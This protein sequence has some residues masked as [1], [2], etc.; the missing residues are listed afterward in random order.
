MG[1]SVPG[2]PL[3]G[4]RSVSPAGDLSDHGAGDGGRCPIPRSGPGYRSIN[5]LPGPFQPFEVLIDRQCFHPQLLEHP[6]LHPLA[7][8]VVHRAGRTKS[9]PRDSLPVNSGAQHIENAFSNAFQVYAAGPAHMTLPP[10]NH[11]F[12][13]LP[14]CVGQFPGSVA[15]LMVPSHG[16][17][18]PLSLVNVLLSLFYHTGHILGSLL[19]QILHFT[20]G[21][22]LTGSPCKWDTTLSMGFWLAA[23]LTTDFKGISTAVV[24]LTLR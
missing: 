10:R 8:V 21:A 2:S 19:L 3:Q 6:S 17:P 4:P 9:L 15:F 16:H 20:T 1:L 5:A 18:P 11:R 14:H 7:E 24:P 12:H 22:D 13:P 23:K